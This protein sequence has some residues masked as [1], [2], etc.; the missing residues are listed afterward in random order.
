MSEILILVVMELVI[1]TGDGL[2][3][4]SHTHTTGIQSRTHHTMYHYLPIFYIADLS[5]LSSTVEKKAIF[6]YFVVA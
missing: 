6:P 5:Q 1:C 4:Y 2:D 3:R